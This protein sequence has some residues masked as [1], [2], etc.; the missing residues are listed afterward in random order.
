MSVSVSGTVNDSDSVGVSVSNGVG[1][2]VINGVGVSAR[3]GVSVSTV[4][5]DGWSPHAVFWMSE[6]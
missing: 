5:V 3:N 2:S 4:S 6:K 1:V